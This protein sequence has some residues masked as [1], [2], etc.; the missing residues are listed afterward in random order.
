ME[1]FDFRSLHPNV[2]L[3]TASDR[4]AGWIGQIY[5]PGRYESRITRRKHAVGGKSFEEQ[6]LPLDSVEEF[7]QHFRVLELDFTF[8]RPLLGKDGEPT[9]NLQVLESYRRHLARD[10]RLMLKVPQAVFAQKVRRGSGYLENA[11][12][13]NAEV[14]RRQF[15]EPAVALLGES[16]AGFVFEQE[17]QRKP[18]RLPA[19]RLAEA[20]DDFFSSIP[21]DGRYHVELR[22]EGYLAP[23]VFAVFE[24]HGIGQVL[25]HWTW[26]PPLARQFSLS[27]NRVLNSRRQLILRLLTPRGMRYEDAYAMAYP[28]RELREDMLDPLMV[29]QTAEL[30]HAGVAQKAQVNVLVNNRAGGNAPLIARR[31]AS[32][33]LH[34]GSAAHEAPSGD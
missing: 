11:E 28:F 4:Y 22:T 15:Y 2:F 30:M 17:Y 7:F 19:P 9:P 3:G 1:E 8:Y 27:D 33:F 25:S 20:L 5:T 18:D 12:Y 29:R 14:F 32:E 26:L 23:P 34:P 16:I 24:K 31:I 6:V 21:R 10:S 13:L